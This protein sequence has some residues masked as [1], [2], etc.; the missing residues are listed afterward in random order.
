MET[1][2]LIINKLN[3]L[4]SVPEIKNNFLPIQEGKFRF[5][6]LRIV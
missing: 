6:Q 2:L 4:P 3:K 1:I 5:W